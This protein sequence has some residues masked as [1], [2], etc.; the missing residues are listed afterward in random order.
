MQV[1]PYLFFEGRCEEALAFYGEKLGA[2][3]EMMMRY[4]D[5]PEAKESCAGRPGMEEK[6]MHSSFRIGDSVLM[7]SDGMCTGKPT[8]QGT[9]LSLTLGDAATAERDFNA[10][11]EGGQVQMAMT[12]TFFAERFGMVADKFGVSWMILGGLKTKPE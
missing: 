2:K 7:A 1:Q 8:F 4:K 5:N 6:V 3:V 11:A 12:P 9:S 10:L